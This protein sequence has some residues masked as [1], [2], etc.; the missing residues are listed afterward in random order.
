M[1]RDALAA[2][3]LFDG[4]DDTQLDQLVAAGSV[5]D[6]GPGE[7]AFTEGHPADSLWVL[8]DGG[9]RLT[10]RLA[11]EEVVLAETTQA[12][13]WAGGLQAYGAAASEATFMATGRT[14]TRS[15]LFRLSS[16]DLGRLLTDWF[17]LGKHLLDGVFQTV[18]GIDAQVRQHSSLVALGT[19]AAGFAHEL[20]N[21]SAAAARAADQLRDLIDD[22]T[23]RFVTL[24]TAPVDGATLGRLVALSDP[25]HR[26]RA[27]LDPLAMADME[28]AVTDRLEGLGVE[29]PWDVAS[30]LVGSGLD[31][32]VIDAVTEVVAPEL[33]GDAVTVVADL[34]MLWTLID[35]VKLATRRV[36]D[37]VQAVRDY[38]QLDRA[39][40]QEVDL[41]EGLETTLTMLRHRLAGIHV[42]RDYADPLPR[43][44]VY[45]SELNQVWTNVLDNAVDALDGAGSIHL[46]TAVDEDAVTV[47]IRDDGPGIPAEVRERVF[48]PF[49][50]TKEVGQ[51]TGL[52]LDIA[53]RIVV[54][55]HD[56]TIEVHSDATGTTVRVRLPLA[57]P[58]G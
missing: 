15:R 10:R 38:T 1:S 13:A 55:R 48:D 21:P 5:V 34:A 31:D 26:P 42:T 27:R 47:E 17:P 12:G 2:T 20:N 50:S 57:A 33:L 3:F 41:H 25:T 39:P 29:A 4:L 8:L 32:T 23:G 22:V 56:G 51:G 49:F 9:L 18:R 53:R 46:H 11:Q 54:D 36:A 37:L 7:V 14:T 35:D 40:R 16:E 30:G 28:S 52:G 19:L 43:M 45:P 6:L 24:A 58:A 44:T